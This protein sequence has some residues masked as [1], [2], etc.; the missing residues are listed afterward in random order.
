ME[1]GDFARAD[2]DGVAHH[3][4]AS[5]RGHCMLSIL[6]EVPLSDEAAAMAF[7]AA[8]GWLLEGL[9]PHGPS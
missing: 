3:L 8:V 6:M 7:D 9:R 4:W 2:P 5:L 1:R